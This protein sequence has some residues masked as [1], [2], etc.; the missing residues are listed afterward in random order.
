[1]L[2]FES[3]NITRDRADTA[4]N[5]GHEKRPGLLV[6]SNCRIL[7]PNG[8]AVQLVLSRWDKAHQR[9]RCETNLHV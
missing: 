2:V 3:E 7:D 1:M 9:G 5:G 8:R 4:S 6:V